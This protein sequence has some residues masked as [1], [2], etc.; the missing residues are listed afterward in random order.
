MTT[1]R[2]EYGGGWIMRSGAMYE[3]GD[4][5]K[6]RRFYTRGEA[7]AWITDRVSKYGAKPKREDVPTKAEPYRGINFFN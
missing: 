7:E 6:V 3:A 4:Y 2:I 5:R 1:K